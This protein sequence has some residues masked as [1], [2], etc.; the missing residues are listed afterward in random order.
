MRKQLIDKIFEIAKKQNAFD[1][2]EKH[3]E[4][5][6]KQEISE[7]IIE[8]GI[9]PEFFDHDSSEE[10]LWA[11]YSD[12]LLAKSLEYL[13]FKA[14]VIRTRGNSADVFAQSDGY[15]LIGDAKCFRL[16]RTAKN[17]KDFKIKALDDW[18]R[19][20]TY[21]VLVG[22]LNQYLGDRSQIYEQAIDRNV[23]LLSYTHLKFLLDNKVNEKLK[24]LWE[25]GMRL[26]T[27]FKAKAGHRGHAYWEEID[28]T[29]VEITGKNIKNLSEYKL[30]EVQII[31][32]NGEEGISY[33]ENKI[34]ELS[35]LSRREAVKMLIKSQ[36]I[37][38]KIQTI[39]KAMNR[40][41]PLL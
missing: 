11:K 41:I 36:K 30:L 22:P 10:K 40:S 23:T 18:R 21:A 19:E 14:Q 1:L 3:L 35:R 26:K 31:K 4:K 20:N 7:Q 8:V 12:I 29:V 5:L 24:R 9:M 33:W 15:T 34:K 6:S 13:G 16:S 39:Q 32:S 2:L 38:Q 27:L 37:E 17:Q 25:V 28:K